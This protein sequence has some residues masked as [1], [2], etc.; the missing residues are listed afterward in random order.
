MRRNDA[1]LIVMT[2]HEANEVYHRLMKR[3]KF[4][5]NGC[6]I[7]QGSKCKEWGYGRV[8]LSGRVHKAHRV[9]YWVTHGINSYEYPHMPHTIMHT[10]DNPSCIKPSHL[11]G[12]TQSDNMRDMMAKGRGKNQFQRKHTYV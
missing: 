2:R 5:T 1:A 7:W 8:W 9:M 6:L 10:C 3:A 4:D 12:G 11:N